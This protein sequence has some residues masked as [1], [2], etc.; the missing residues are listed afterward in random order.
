MGVW[1]C[2]KIGETEKDS[3]ATH[4][5]WL[6]RHLLFTAILSTELFKLESHVFLEQFYSLVMR[7]AFE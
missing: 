7:N 4:L 2:V 6:D 3:E 1:R 5:K